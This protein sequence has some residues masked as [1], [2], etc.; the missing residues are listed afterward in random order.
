MKIIWRNKKCGDNLSQTPPA[1]PIQYQSLAA[2]LWK[3][4]VAQC[5]QL[6]RLL[7]T[8]FIQPLY[9]L[10]LYCSR[11]RLRSRSTL[12]R[13]NR[14]SS[15][16]IGE[17]FSERPGFR[18]TNQTFERPINYR[19]NMYNSQLDPN[20]LGSV[21]YALWIFLLTTQYFVVNA[22]KRTTGPPVILL[23][24]TRRDGC[25]RSSTKCSGIGYFF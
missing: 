10:K 22:G 15:T 16:L 2:I 3:I 6:Y 11:R 8:V 4:F 9:A 18:E 23:W 24:Q 20:P 25:R 1:A 14:D 12:F 5:I 7:I 21:P 17:T 13:S 19:P